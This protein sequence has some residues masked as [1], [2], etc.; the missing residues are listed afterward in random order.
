MKLEHQYMVYGLIAQ[1]KYKFNPKTAELITVKSSQV[2]KIMY[3]SKKYIYRFNLGYSNRI[4][5]PADEVVY[6]LYFGIFNPTA[7]VL[8]KDGDIFNNLKDN[9]TVTVGRHEIAPDVKQKITDL[10]AD[11]KGYAEI[12]RKLNVDRGTVKQIIKKH[13]G[14]VH[15]HQYRRTKSILES[16]QPPNYSKK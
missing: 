6:L 9:I 1:K 13:Y 12:G 10:F 2:K 5:V 11:G 4:D 7:K 14:E 16:F 8:H 3:I 15:P